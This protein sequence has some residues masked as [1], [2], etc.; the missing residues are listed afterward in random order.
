MGAINH[1]P[2][3]EGV[4]VVN[5]KPFH[6]NSV[7]VG[8]LKGRK[9]TVCLCS[10]VGNFFKNIVSSIFSGIGAFFSRIYHCFDKQEN[11]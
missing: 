4:A 3:G 5:F 10:R 7:S 8:N 2:Q 1:K 9:V 11:I 6:N